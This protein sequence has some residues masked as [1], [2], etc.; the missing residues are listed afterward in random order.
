MWNTGG[1]WPTEEYKGVSKSSRTGRL[2]RQ[3]QMVQL[4]ATRFSCIAILW[5]GL[6]SFAAT[7]LCVASQRV[8][9]RYRLSPEILGKRSY[10]LGTNV[11]GIYTINNYS[12][13]TTKFV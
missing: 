4:S 8:F 11:S 12:N 9:V 6:A 13:T 10:K 1:E 7:T 3:L 2:E 5:A